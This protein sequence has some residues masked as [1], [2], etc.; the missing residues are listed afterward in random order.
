VDTLDKLLLAYTIFMI[1]VGGLWLL[2]KFAGGLFDSLLRKLRLAPTTP[3][4][5]TAP[6]FLASLIGTVSLI[7]GTFT[8]LMVIA[9]NSG[10]LFA[11]IGIIILLIGSGMLLYGHGTDKQ[12]ADRNIGT[13]NKVYKIGGIAIPGILLVIFITVNQNWFIDTIVALNFGTLES[14]KRL[15]IGAVVFIGIGLWLL[16]SG[17]GKDDH[18]VNKKGNAP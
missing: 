15:L 2:K 6:D 12:I 5:G 14:H 16:M 18:A 7:V 10:F 3:A 8:V 1:V 11:M 9:K 13:S 17:D 4:A